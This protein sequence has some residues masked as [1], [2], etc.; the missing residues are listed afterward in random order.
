MLGR[1][2]AW[3]TVFTFCE[4]VISQK[5]AAGRKREADISA[6]LFRRRRGGAAGR[7]NAR[8]AIAPP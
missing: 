4:N 8:L 6:P 5:E 1:E 7:A 2:E 3:G